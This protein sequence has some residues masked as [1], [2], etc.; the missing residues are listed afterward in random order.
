MANR[1]ANIKI[2]NVKWDFG[3]VKIQAAKKLSTK[4]RDQIEGQVQ[5]RLSNLERQMIAEIKNHI[6]SQEIIGGS[7]DPENAPNLSGTLGGYGN[8]WAFI[9]FYEGDDPIAS[10]V[11]S[12]EGRFRVSSVRREG[13]VVKVEGEKATIEEVYENTPMPW[14]S[15]RSWAESIHQGISGFGRYLSTDSERSRSGGG[16]EVPNTIRGGKYRNVPYLAPIFKRAQEKLQSALRE[17]FKFNE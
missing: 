3:A 7:R 4:L 5:R 1:G 10:V 16:L 6:I 9:G 13:G 15:G 8:L 2:G 11:G 17:T 14:A 12:I